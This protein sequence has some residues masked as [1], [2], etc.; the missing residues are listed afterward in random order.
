MSSVY[1]HIVP[2]GKMYI[3]MTVHDNAERRWGEG[4][5][6]Y[7]GMFFGR[8]I[9]KYG[10]DNIQHIVLLSGISKEVA[11]EC[12]KYLIE[13]YHTR[14]ST[15]GYNCCKGGRTNAGYHHTEEYKEWLRKEMKGRYKG[16]KSPL[17]GVPLSEEQKQQISKTLT[18][19]KQSKETK[20]KRSN[21]LMGHEVTEETRKK[22]GSGNRGKTRTPEQRKML[23]ETLKGKRLG[24]QGYW[25]GKH[26]SE[27]HKEKI[28]QANSGKSMSEETKQ[29]LSKIFKGK[30]MGPMSEEHKQRIRDAWKRRREASA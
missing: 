28:R 1:V 12:E 16:E 30:K 9:R 17:Y 18:G 23:S 21:S 8:A 19:R 25:E 26:L 4:G 14:Y 3:G 27:E 2:N 5:K 11:C 10:W 6:G 29:K 13:K 22:I 24:H 7:D 15:Y 20:Q